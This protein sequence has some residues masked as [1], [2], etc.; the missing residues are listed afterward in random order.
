LVAVACTV[1]SAATL[2]SM[3]SDRQALPPL[4]AAYP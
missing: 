1:P 2:T 4:Q 3:T